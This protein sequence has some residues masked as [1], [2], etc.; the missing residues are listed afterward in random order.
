MIVT[1][2]HLSCAVQAPRV[3]VLA[4]R[5]LAVWIVDLVRERPGDESW[6][7]GGEFLDERPDGRVHRQGLERSVEGEAVEA[8]HVDLA[9]VFRLDLGGLGEEAIR[10]GLAI[11][12]LAAVAGGI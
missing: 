9:V 3:C 8:A 10:A 7:I 4:L 1:W 5:R 11:G 6:L 2:A 12:P